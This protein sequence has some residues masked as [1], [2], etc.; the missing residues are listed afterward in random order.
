MKPRGFAQGRSE[1]IAISIEN[2]EPERHPKTRIERFRA[3]LPRQANP[4]SMESSIFAD[5]LENLNER[6][7]NMAEL[8]AASANLLLTNEDRRSVFSNVSPTVT[9]ETAANFVDAVEKIYNNGDCNA[10]ISIVL[11]LKR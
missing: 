2:G 8:V 5:D 3:I 1:R 11:N 9:A 10:R 4:F 7:N 6:R